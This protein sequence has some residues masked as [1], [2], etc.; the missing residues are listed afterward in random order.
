MENEI[1][2]YESKKKSETFF[3]IQFLILSA[4]MIFGIS[5]L[6]VEEINISCGFG[7]EDLLIIFIPNLLVMICLKYI[8]KKK[9]KWEWILIIAGCFWSLGCGVSRYFIIC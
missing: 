3:D 9:K 7:I 2:D 8:L 4:F 5:L 1:L 6:H